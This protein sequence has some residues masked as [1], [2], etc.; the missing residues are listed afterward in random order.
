MRS[1]KPHV[2]ITP[3][4]LT[5][6]R[7]I[8]SLII[9]YLIFIPSF[10]IRM[11]ALFLFI[12]AVVSDFFDGH[13]ARKRGLITTVGKILDPIADKILIL[14]MYISFSLLN[15]YSFWWLVPI[16]IR[17]ILVTV[18]RLILLLKG[19]VIAAEKLGKW[20]VGF[21][22]ASLFA[23]WLCLLLRDQVSEWLLFNL[24]GLCCI[25]LYVSLISAIVLTLYSGLIFCIKNNRSFADV[26]IARFMGTFFFF[27]TF[28]WAPGTVGSIGGVIAYL[29]LQHNALLYS[30]TLGTLFIV[31][32]WSARRMCEACNDPDPREVVID[33]VVGM[34]ITLFLIPC[35]R[36]AILI[37]FILFRIFD[38]VKPWP[39]RSLERFKNGYGV[40]LDDIVAGVFANFLLQIIYYKFLV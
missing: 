34:L 31:G 8:L 21:Q 24:Y 15:V 38:I 32:T 5:V 2:I 17:E 11:L 28:P 18:L 16:I 33:E 19:K 7:I 35:H 30:I 12:L 13:I 29:F 40:M 37:G 14:G 25:L 26:G 22:I 23:S 39:I 6:L 9:F 10:M 3:N 36:E 27:G 1:Q 4:M 20:K